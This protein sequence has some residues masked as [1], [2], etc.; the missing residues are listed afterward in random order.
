M[1]FEISAYSDCVEQTEKIKKTKPVWHHFLHFYIYFQLDLDITTYRFSTFS[2]FCPFTITNENTNINTILW[3]RN[4]RT[5][6]VSTPL[7][8]RVLYYYRNSFLQIFMI[9]INLV[10][11]LI[12][13]CV[14]KKTVI[15]R[16][17]G[18]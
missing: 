15:E 4:I 12:P 8:N 14:S 1:H 10:E 5:L 2:N 13:A 11:Y 7:P 3:G 18:N 16:Y 9:Y 17:L 6:P